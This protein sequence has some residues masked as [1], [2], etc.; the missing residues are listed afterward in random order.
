MR[1]RSLLQCDYDTPLIDVLLLLSAGELAQLDDG[2]DG[3]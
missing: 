3:S 2:Q 1:Y